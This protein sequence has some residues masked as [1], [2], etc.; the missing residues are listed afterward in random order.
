MLNEV[1]SSKVGSKNTNILLVA[2]LVLLIGGGAFGIGYKVGQS[3]SKSSLASQ[4]GQAARNSQPNNARR[5]GGG[6]IIGTITAGDG[7][8]VTVQLQDGSSKIALISATTT[9]NKASAGTTTDLK[10]GEKV[11]IFGSTNA[12]GSVTAQSIQLNPSI[13]ATPSGTPNGQ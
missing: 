3:N 6:Q 7:K 13:R 9:I 10:T 5:M 12:D 8:T 4:F 1:Q 11:A 2:I